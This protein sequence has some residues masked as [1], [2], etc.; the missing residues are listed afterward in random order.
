MKKQTTEMDVVF[1]F[2]RK[3]TDGGWSETEAGLLSVN[4]HPRSFVLVVRAVDS[5]HPFF[6]E[7]STMCFTFTRATG[8]GISPV[9]TRKQHSGCARLCRGQR[10]N[11]ALSLIAFTK[12]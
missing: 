6:I 3:R 10:F 5:T 7:Y 11:L 4:S 12:T 2:H 8:C 9:A 1:I